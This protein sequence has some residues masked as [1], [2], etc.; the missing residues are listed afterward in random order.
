MDVWGVQKLLVVCPNSCIYKT[1]QKQ[2]EEDTD[3]K[4]MPLVGTT[5]QRK[6]LL[7]SMDEQVGKTVCVINYEG[8]KFMFGEKRETVR[9]QGTAVIKINKF[10]ID[11]P[12]IDELQ[13]IG[14][15]GIV[16]D[17]AHK[18]QSISSTQT[19][20]AYH[21]SKRMKYSILMTG[22]PFGSSEI[23]LWAEYFV[24]N[25]GRSLGSS[26]WKYKKDYF[27]QD[28]WG[29]WNIRGDNSRKLLLRKV[30]PVTLRFAKEECIDLPP[31]IRQVREGKMLGKQGKVYREMMKD[32]V[33][34]VGNDEL[35]L[36]NATALTAKLK[37]IT[38]GFFFQPDKSVVTF[39]SVKEELL[40][41]LLI[42]INDKIIIFHHYVPEAYLIEKI[43]KKLKIKYSSMRGEIKNKNQQFDK[44]IEDPS[45]KVIVV[46]PQ[47]GGEGLDGFQHVCSTAIFFS[48]V[49]KSP[50]TREQCEGR[51]ERSG[52]KNSCLFIDLIV[53]HSVDQDAYDSRGDGIAVSKK[54]LKWMQKHGG[55]S[56]V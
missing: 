3:Y 17:E 38:S 47:S 40:K 54:M 5:T 11:Y 44:F 35:T 43:L 46:Q 21:L 14:F 22:T 9:K 52:Q 33:S 29:G 42:E 31:V 32:W 8:L 39:P 15:T 45:V 49:G 6:D 30:A 55:V 1:W 26:F 36:S 13:K 2:I 24:L 28:F 23:N 7:L 4:F 48:S 37:Q 50:R 19:L 10:M 25:F 20:I 16:C 41:E 27:E 56:R 18:L 12:W 51:I 53:N 34:V